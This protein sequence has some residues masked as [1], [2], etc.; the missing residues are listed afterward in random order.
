M[1]RSAIGIRLNFKR[2]RYVFSGIISLYGKLTTALV[3]NAFRIGMCWQI[4]ND[5]LHVCRF[6]KGGTNFYHESMVDRKKS[7]QKRGNGQIDDASFWSL[8]LFVYILMKS[9][10]LKK[11]ETEKQKEKFFVLFYSCFRM[12]Q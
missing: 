11:L 1:I 6:Y 3:D 9:Y 5:A 8:Y 2:G 12:L 4:D 10:K 7:Q